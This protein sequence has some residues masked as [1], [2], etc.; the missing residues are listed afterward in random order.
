[1][2]VS[3]TPGRVRLRLAEL[4]NQDM[5]GK[6]LPR[7]K[8]IAGIKSVEIKTLTGS[9]LIEYDPAV[10]STG[11][12]VELGRTLARQAGIADNPQA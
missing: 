8:A 9:L 10:I 7:I 5:A 4:K 3:F 6:L 2:I 12:L 11:Q 1:M